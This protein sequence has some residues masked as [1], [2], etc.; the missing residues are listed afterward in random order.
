MSA[1]SSGAGMITV[2]PRR[3]RSWVV[4]GEESI[5]A[6]KAQFEI[7]IDDE[8]HEAAR[9]AGIQTRVAESNARGVLDGIA[10]NADKR[11][12]L[13]PQSPIARAQAGLAH[14]A[15]GNHEAAVNSFRHA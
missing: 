9:L 11:A 6:P 15:C 1:S 5:L 14:L 12:A 2:A 13:F 10:R 4:F 7:S 8:G 3:P